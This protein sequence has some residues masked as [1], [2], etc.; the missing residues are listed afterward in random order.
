MDVPVAAPS[1]P[2]KLGL[3]DALSIVVGVVIGAGIFLVPNLVAQELKSAQAILAV[4]TFAGVVSFF[5][6]L[7]C[8]ELG[9]MFPSTGGQYVF[10]REAYGP[11]I[12]FLCGWSMFLVAR[13]AQV[14]WLAM[15]LALYG[16]YFIPLSPMAS[17]ALALGALAI[18][19]GI[20]YRGVKAGAVVQNVFTLAKVAGLLVIIGSALLWSGKAAPIASA[21]AGG[22]SASSFG[23]ALIA[24]VLAYDGWVQLSFVAG[25]IRNPQ[26]N[27]LLALALGSVACIAIYL[28]ANLAYL[29]VLPIAEIAAS[30]H[31]GSTVAERVLGPLGGSLVSL[32]ILLSVIGSLNG[33]F[34]TSPRVYFAQAGDGLFF[35]RFAEVHPRYQT[36]G[37][38]I[39]A[40]AGWAAVLLVSGSYE[41]L[42]DYSMFAIWLSYGLMVAGLIVLRVKQP[43]I[44]R[45]YK[46]WGYP[47]TPALFLV[48]T[49][50]FLVNMLKTR[51]VPSFAALALIAA[52][53]PVYFVWA[54]RTRPAE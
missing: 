38:A 31:V 20:N 39:V 37:F 28:L 11:L 25:E 7:A 14:A 21:V 41:S 32:I 29:R 12:G 6:S 26:R 10:L 23:I 34:L 48:I 47:V 15:A 18:F 33:C 40:Q 51:P 54:R 3:F 35:R 42:L 44:A 5:G 22:F 13:S 53:I 50:W 24:C 4:W 8:A 9:T 16:S 30:N 17:K 45:P 27:V 46:M 19:S 52:G 36:P 43:G 1:L 2:R 49:G